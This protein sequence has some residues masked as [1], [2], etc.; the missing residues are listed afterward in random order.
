MEEISWLNIGALA[1]FLC[2]W[3]GYTHF[4]YNRAKHSSQ[5]LSVIM[6]QRRREW[7]RQMLKREVRMADAALVASLERNVTFL[8]SSSMLVLAGL[9]TV[10]VSIGRLQA[11]LFDVPFYIESTPFL[12]H[13][14]LMVLIAI[15]VYAF[16]T[17]TWSMRQY[18]FVS[19]MIGSAPTPKEVRE[20]PEKVEPFVHPCAKIIDLAGHTYNYGLRAFYF[21]L[22][23]LAWFINGWFF[24]M[25]ATLVV[26]VLYHREF[27][28]RP[29]L[30]MRKIEIFREGFSE[31]ESKEESKSESKTGHN[32]AIRDERHAE[33][34]IKA[35]KE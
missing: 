9:L 1:W 14:K 8:A 34:S 27:R 15:Y 29:L 23:V 6:S 28:S 30:E 11:V 33:S 32:D 5:G 22:S 31:D 26:A 13:L 10:F 4:A 35:E 21:S 19:V 18:G 3:V 12:L 17:F 24:I 16:F 7:V 20:Y 2:L 25:A